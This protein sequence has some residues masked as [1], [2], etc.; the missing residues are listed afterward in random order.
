MFLGV[1]FVFIMCFFF[2]VIE[3]DVYVEKKNGL[4][5][6]ICLILDFVL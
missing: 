6:Y 4:E 3:M 5:L 2:V 1:Y